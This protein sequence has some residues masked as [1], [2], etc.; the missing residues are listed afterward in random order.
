MSLYRLIILFS[1]IIGYNYVVIINIFMRE[2]VLN[3]E[4]KG[5]IYI[6]NKLTS[7]ILI[8]LLVLVFISGCSFNDDKKDSPVKVAIAWRL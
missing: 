2:N 5:S 4:I 8:P 1:L 7:I 6:V 3:K